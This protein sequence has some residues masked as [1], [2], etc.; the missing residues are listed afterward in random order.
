MVQKFNLKT[1]LFG[2]LG[3]ALQTSSNHRH[4]SQSVS[5]FAWL[6]SDKSCALKGQPP[7]KAAWVAKSSHWGVGSSNE[8]TWPTVKADFLVGKK[9]SRSCQRMQM[10]PCVKE[11]RRK[12]ERWH[13]HDFSQKKHLLYFICAPK[14]ISLLACFGAPWI[15]RCPRFAT[16]VRLQC[17]GTQPGKL[18]HWSCEEKQWRALSLTSELSLSFLSKYFLQMDT[19]CKEWILSKKK[20]LPRSTKSQQSGIPVLH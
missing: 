6:M 12:T 16:D 19:K 10:E 7:F 3:F 4:H 11:G 8:R 17:D 2:I 15:C 14:L 5:T 18:R 1:L 20:H 13:V 9:S